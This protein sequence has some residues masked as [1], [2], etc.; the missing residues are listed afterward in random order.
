MNNA[1]VWLMCRVNVVVSLIA[2]QIGDETDSR[3]F[4]H[5]RT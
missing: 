3:L 1:T 5:L 4:Q 2:D